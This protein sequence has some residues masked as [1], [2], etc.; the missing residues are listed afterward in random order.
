MSSQSGHSGT[1]TYGRENPW[2]RDVRDSLNRQNPGGN[3][4]NSEDGN[5][6]VAQP[7]R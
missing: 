1:G 5:V 2:P 7:S 4:S 3:D 6:L